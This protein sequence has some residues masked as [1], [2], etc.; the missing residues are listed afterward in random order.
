MGS[1]RFRSESTA[2]S[3]VGEK[4]GN[5]E[6]VEGGKLERWTND[7]AEEGDPLLISNIGGGGKEFV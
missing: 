3:V 2:V 7:V 1:K 5:V 6:W 4:I